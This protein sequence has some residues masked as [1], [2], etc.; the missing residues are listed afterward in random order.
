LTDWLPSGDGL[1]AY[2]IIAGLAE[3]G[4]RVHV[5][6]PYADLRNPIPDRVTVDQM[7]TRKDQPRPGAL[8]YMRWTRR[9]L[10]RTRNT[11]SVDLIH[12][13]NPVFTLRSL[14][15]AYSGIPVVLGP[16]SSRWP[17]DSDHKRPSPNDFL[18]R[19]TQLLKDICVRTQHRNAKAILLSTQAAL[20]NVAQP[21]RM[22]DRLFILPPGIDDREFS[23]GPK[24]SGEN[25][26]ILFLAN[27]LMRK[28][29][30]TLLDAFE[31]LSKRMPLVR[32]TIA[33]DGPAIDAVKA[34]AAA[35]HFRARVQFLGH[36][37]RA[38]IP[39]LLR[40]CSVYCLPS[41]GEPFGMT[42][43]EAMACGKP[44]I[45]TDAGG[46][47][48]MVSDRGGRRVPVKD[49]IALTHALEELLSDPELCRRM[50]EYNRA[51]VETHYTWPIVV[52]RL[53]TIYQQV[54]SGGS[55][56]NLDRITNSD[57]AE[58]RS[59]LTPNFTFEHASQPQIRSTEV[60]V[61]A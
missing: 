61:R 39:D 47:S 41:Y 33:G 7:N 43:L 31:E 30:F 59:R 44:L 58:Y 40:Q 46:L 10:N 48:Y 32:L 22:I 27:L 50:G 26:T 2:H 56:I 3:R 1:V 57:I 4:H 24:S 38:G 9:M 19:G 17:I 23:P 20:N 5:V 8:S 16:H 13:L 21:E 54:L 49:P 34:R 25:P 29:I 35:S 55:Q 60:A 18:F 45:V 53:E 14:A 11:M 28:G 42:A 37:D 52:S 6:T 51:Q 36:I 15:F 12:E